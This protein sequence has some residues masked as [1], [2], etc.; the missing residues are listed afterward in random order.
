MGSFQ[1]GYLIALLIAA[2]DGVYIGAAFLAGLAGFPALMSHCAVGFSGVIFGLIP[3]E[4]RYS[5][6]TQRSF[7]GLFSVPTAAYPWVLLVLWQVLIPQSSF[8]GH[9]SGL[10]VGQ[11]YA[12]GMLRW[13]VPTAEWA[14]QAERSAPLAWCMASAAWIANTGSDGS[15]TGGG[16][17]LESLLPITQPRNGSG[18][19]LDGSWMQKPWAA[20]SSLFGRGQGDTAAGD[21]SSNGSA[22]PA[23]P[24]GRVVGGVAPVV[25][26]P[27]AAAAAAAEARVGGNK[28][29]AS[30]RTGLP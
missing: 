17:V 7:F 23:G 18:Y 9:L 14:Q 28:L 3:V 1:L 30:T 16:G 12:L 5:S 13:V 2:G 22:A 11:L 15:S 21:Q 19:V 20:I 8:L 29:Y 24:A 27:K 26:E 25:Q 10:A 6:A 4:S